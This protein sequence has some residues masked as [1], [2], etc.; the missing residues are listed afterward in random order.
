MVQCRTSAMPLF[1][2]PLRLLAP[3]G[4]TSREAGGA[5]DGGLRKAADAA[6]TPVGGSAQ[7]PRGVAGPRA[8]GQRADG[9]SA[10]GDQAR[11]SGTRLGRMEMPRCVSGREGLAPHDHR[12]ECVELFGAAAWVGVRPHPRRSLLKTRVF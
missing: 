4:A 10:Q 6:W 1:A 5:G 2:R 3:A 9:G 12:S 11:L 8:A 7:V